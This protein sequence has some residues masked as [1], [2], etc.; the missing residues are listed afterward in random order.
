MIFF[1]IAMVQPVCCKGNHFLLLSFG[2]FKIVDCLFGRI[3]GS[4]SWRGSGNCGMDKCAYV[5]FFISSLLAE[6]NMSQGEVIMVGP[7]CRWWERKM[8]LRPKGYKYYS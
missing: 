8:R 1:Q 2:F 6:I 4:N 5:C 7:Y 3:S